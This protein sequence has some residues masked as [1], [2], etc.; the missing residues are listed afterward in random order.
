MHLYK[1]NMITLRGSRA[2][3]AKT[4]KLTKKNS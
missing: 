3:L 2:K 4:G 1:E